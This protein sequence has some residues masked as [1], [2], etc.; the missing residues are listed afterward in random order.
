MWMENLDLQCV[1]GK[2]TV[3]DPLYET[4]RVV[5][6]TCSLVHT[7]HDRRSPTYVYL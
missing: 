7:V 2:S 1:V 4:K 6:P 3:G 5:D